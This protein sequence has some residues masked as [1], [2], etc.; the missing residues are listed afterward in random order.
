[1]SFAGYGSEPWVDYTTDTATVIDWTNQPVSFQTLETVDNVGTNYEAGFDKADEMFNSS[2]YKALNSSDNQKVMI[3]ISD[4]V[5]TY[6][7][8][9][10]DGSRCGNGGSGGSNE[11]IVR[12]PTLLAFDDFQNKN[13]DVITYTVGFSSDLTGENAT[14]AGV[15]RYM[16]EIGG[17]QFVGAADGDALLTAME[18]Y[19]LGGGYYK[20]AVITDQ[21]SD[22]VDYYAEQPDCMV[23]MT[24]N[25][26]DASKAQKT[27][28]WANGK[29]TDAGAGI[30]DSVYYDTATR[31]IKAKFKSSYALE[32]DAQYELSF[33]VKLSSAAYEQRSENQQ[34]KSADYLSAD[35]KAY[36][37]DEN[38]DYGDNDTSSGEDGFRSNKKAAQDLY[39]YPVVQT[40]TVDMTVKKTNEYGELLSGA[41]FTL[42]QDA[43]SAV[44]EKNVVYGGKTGSVSALPEGRYVEIESFYIG[45]GLLGV[46]K[47]T[48]KLTDLQPGHYYLVETASPTGYKLPTSAYEFVL[49][50]GM[51]TALST[52][53]GTESMMIGSGTDTTLTIKNTDVG[54]ELP[55]TGGKGRMRIIYI[56]LTLVLG[57]LAG[58]MYKYSKECKRSRRIRHRRH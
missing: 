47:G 5:P 50:Q 38:T 32:M 57:A 17:G 53:T 8:S 21:L 33:N 49:S 54:V 4:G 18:D 23:T 13:S 3:F 41:E 22:Y 55:E 7:I 36:T 19:I 26:A 51:V 30:I 37:G 11:L 46:G 40:K 24:T 56:G 9:D 1:V 39:D 31:T 27:I 6:Y 15:L 45:S 43:S 35:G 12:E 52:D 16:A 34:T 25:A 29:T 44:A 20:D 58:G 10:E 28:L 2:S 48:E 42:Y 14:S